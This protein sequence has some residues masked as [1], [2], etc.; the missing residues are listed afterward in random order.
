MRL[1]CDDLAA[2][3][4]ASAAPV[5]LKRLHARAGEGAVLAARAGLGFSDLFGR[6]LLELV[7]GTGPLLVVLEELHDVRLADHGPHEQ[8]AHRGKLVLFLGFGQRRVD[9]QEVGVLATEGGDH[10]QDGERE[11]DLRAAD[12]HGHEER[13]GAALGD[14]GRL[15]GKGVHKGDPNKENEANHQRDVAP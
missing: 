10:L 8:V 7:G 5:F 9:V 13:R 6:L 15:A 1:P 2:L 4:A 14:L 11:R 3:G 12:E